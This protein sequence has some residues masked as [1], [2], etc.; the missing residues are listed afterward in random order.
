MFTK[1]ERKRKHNC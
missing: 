1:E